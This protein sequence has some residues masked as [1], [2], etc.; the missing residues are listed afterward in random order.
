MVEIPVMRS[1]GKVIQSRINELRESRSQIITEEFLKRSDDKII[2]ELNGGVKSQLQVV[3]RLVQKVLVY[4]SG[5]IE[6][7]PKRDAEG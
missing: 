2:Q 4:R 6:I 5:Y 1:Q 7:I 3:H